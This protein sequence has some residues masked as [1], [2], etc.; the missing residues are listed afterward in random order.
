MSRIHRLISSAACVC[1]LFVIVSVAPAATILKL[2]LGGVGPDVSMTGAGVLSTT[3][4]GD[5][6]TTG[7]QNTAIEYTGFLDPL[8][9]DVPL[10]VASYTLSNL[11]TSAPAQVVGPVVIQDY[12]GGTLNLY[13]PANNLLLSGSL[14]NSTLSGSAGSGVV[15]TTSLGTVTGGSLQS[16]L[17]GNSLSMTMNLSNINGGAGLTVINNVLQQFSAD[18]AV[19]ISAEA[20]VPEPVSALLMVIGLPF[21]AAWRRRAGR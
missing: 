13:G 4:D 19:N 8:F 20:A 18:A 11:Q 1:A 6:L 15:F 16:Y 12:M 21:V 3:S 10:S 2:N 17:V 14:S 5:A 7:N 9:A